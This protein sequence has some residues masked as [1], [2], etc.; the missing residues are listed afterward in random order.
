M[1]QEL[2]NQVYQLLPLLAT[3]L[4]GL[5]GSFVYWGKFKT[6]LHAVTNFLVEVDKAIYDNQIT[7]EEFRRIY[8]AG[9]KIIS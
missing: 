9:K 2:L 1:P 3:F 6:K 8:E 4:L 5:I 7:E